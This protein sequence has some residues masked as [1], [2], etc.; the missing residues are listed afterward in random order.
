MVAGVFDPGVGCYG[1]DP[2]SSTKGQDGEGAVA[3]WVQ[4]AL[5]AVESEVVE[6]LSAVLIKNGAVAMGRKTASGGG[7]IWAH[8]P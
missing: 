5:P 2:L 8:H 3:C 6:K 4:Q 7:F 1:G